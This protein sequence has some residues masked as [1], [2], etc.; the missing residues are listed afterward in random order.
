[1]GCD[2]CFTN[3]H[4]FLAFWVYGLRSP[5]ALMKIFRPLNLSTIFWLC[6]YCSPPR[7]EMDFSGLAKFPDTVDSDHLVP[8]VRY[9]NGMTVSPL[10]S[11]L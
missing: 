10:Q 1:L 11:M 8:D 5:L 2:T 3:A 6:S 4:G 7:V 9:V